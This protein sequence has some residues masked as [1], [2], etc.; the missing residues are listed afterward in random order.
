MLCRV[1]IGL[2]ALLG[3]LFAS[4]SALAHREHAGLSELTLNR[5]S[6]ELEI[7]HRLHWHDIY[8]ALEF[9]AEEVESFALDQAPA[10]LETFA[11]EGFSLTYEDGGEITQS[12]VGSERDGDYVFI[13]FTAQPPETGRAFLIDNRLLVEE[14]PQQSNLT[15]IRVGE[16]IASL[17]QTPQRR[18]AGRA[19]F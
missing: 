6:G 11:R 13:Y 8:L 9:S 19:A 17:R 7:V 14:Q 10:R 18:G 5:V 12:Y 3:A 16:D 2:L 15:N 1:L 4:D